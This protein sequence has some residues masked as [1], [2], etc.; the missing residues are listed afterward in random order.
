MPRSEL[1]TA[2]ERLQLL[3]FPEDMAELIRLL[4]LSKSDIAFVQQHRGDHKSLRHCRLG[5]ISDGR[6]G[7]WPRTK[8]RMS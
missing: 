6:G 1:L 4:T 8:I 2:T 3:V 5:A 7:F